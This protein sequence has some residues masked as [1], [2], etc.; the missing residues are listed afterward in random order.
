[1]GRHK[2]NL[3]ATDSRYSLSRPVLSER[4]ITAGPDSPQ[5]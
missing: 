5:P 3:Q 4:A 2:A 1:M